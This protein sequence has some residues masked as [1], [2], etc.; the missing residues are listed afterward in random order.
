MPDSLNIPDDKSVQTE[1]PVRKRGRPRKASD[2]LIPI[3]RVP[4][5]VPHSE[6]P[7]SAGGGG[8][9][10]SCTQG[11][12]SSLDLSPKRKPGRPRKAIANV[13][14]SQALPTGAP[15]AE[16]PQF[17][18]AGGGHRESESH[19]CSASPL[20]SQTGSDAVADGAGHASFD[21][22][23]TSVRP[24]APQTPP[25][26]AVG[27]DQWSCDV[28]DTGAS[29]TTN[30][31]AIVQD[32]SSGREVR[33]SEKMLPRGGLPDLSLIIEEIQQLQR[34]RLFCLKSDFRQKNATMAEIR[35]LLGWSRDNPEAANKKINKRAMSLVAYVEAEHDVET[36]ENELKSLRDDASEK[37][38][39]ALVDR[40]RKAQKA[41]D[42][43]GLSVEDTMAA[44]ENQEIII[45]A[46]LSREHWEIL[47]ANTEKSMKGLA[48]K[49]PIFIWSEK[50]R[51][52]GEIGIVTIIGETGDLSKYAT[53]ER[54]W[55][56]LGLAVIKGKRQGSPGRGA[57]AQDW[58]DHGYA[59]MRRSQSWK[60][61]DALIRSQW[62]GAKEN[63]DTGEITEGH[64]LGPY[65][66]LYARQKIEEH[67][68]NDAGEYASVAKEIVADCKARR[69]KANPENLAGRLTKKHLDNKARRI[70]E[71]QLIEDIWREWN[72]PR[73]DAG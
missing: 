59:K 60:I 21:G 37:T 54:V 29:P 61:N 8:Q 5:G 16:T 67:R 28:H 14:A 64:A 6:I 45:A 72:R 17:A 58:V 4:T 62:R 15:I 48:K 43:A 12:F 71:K 2:V 24:S 70:V 52:L 23:G 39:L 68:R 9:L 50:V 51:G 73:Q 36:A 10:T 42:K 49:L 65:G 7:P 44:K 55:K 40:I 26:M 3:D 11:A 32:G 18:A 30:T 13:E 19:I 35:R 53:K 34:K 22:H 56:R 46:Y 1:T 63:E 33:A 57:S 25:E 47:I 20:S 31:A 41:Q 27:G 69:T 66:E 38:R